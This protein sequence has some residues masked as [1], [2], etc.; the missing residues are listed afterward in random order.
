MLFQSFGLV[1]S[2]ASKASCCHASVYSFGDSNLVS[3]VFGDLSWLPERIWTRALVS[4]GVLGGVLLAFASSSECLRFL[5]GLITTPSDEVSFTLLRSCRISIEWLV[6]EGRAPAPSVLTSARVLVPERLSPSL[7][8][9]RSPSADLPFTSSGRE[10]WPGDT[11]LESGTSAALW[12]VRL[13]ISWS[14]VNLQG[15]S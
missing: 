1:P 15:D 4:A 12:P 10:S 5:V 6:E 2:A 3:G 11:T 9:G 7:G 8:T 14:W 13:D